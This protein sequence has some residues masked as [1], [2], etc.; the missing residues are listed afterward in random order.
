MGNLDDVT[1]LQRMARNA[2]AAPGLQ[3]LAGERAAALEAFA[4]S[5]FP[6]T[7]EEDWRYTDIS[8]AARRLGEPGGE[9]DSG[10]TPALS[11]L[12]DAAMLPGPLAARAVFVGGRFAAGRSLLPAGGALG[13]NPF[14]C[15][16]PG[17]PAGIAAR[18]AGDKVV[19]GRLGALN[20][21]LLEDG[22]HVTVPQGL[23]VE[24]PVHVLFAATA[25]IA[26]NRLVLDLGPGSHCT[27]LEHHLGAGDGVSNTVTDARLGEGAQLR[28][29]KLQLEAREATHLASQHFATGPGARARLLHLDFG[30]ALARNDLAVR[31][32][33][34]GAAVDADGLFVADDG[35]HLDNHTRIDHEA[36]QTTSREAWRGIADGRG[37][38]VFN[39]KV[40]VHAGADG[41]DARLVSQ[42]LLLSVGAEI[43]TKPEL[44]IHADDVKCSH[45]ATVGQIDPA[46]L[47][48]LR[49]RGIPHDEARRML[50]AAFARQVL[51]RLPFAALDA[52]VMAALA[53]RL[54]DLREVATAS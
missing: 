11:A 41:S 12:L 44:E 5:G 23:V 4:A 52:H 26:Q 51:L 19:N 34:R 54:R 10:E 29:V 46:A 9:P 24:H 18:V 42:N 7:T 20:L 35:R 15:Q 47:F 48:Y 8:G 39:G 2:A 38:G 13:V 37:R 28:Y 6:G 32:A 40:I 16:P 53:G 21:A 27:V 31:L 36:P 3:W 45:G 33:G 49:S 14:S 50:I 30:A 1:T 17:T 25:G 22:L 43:D